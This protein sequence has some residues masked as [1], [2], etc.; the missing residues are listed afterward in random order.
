[1]K[2]FWVVTPLSTSLSQICLG[3]SVLFSF[4]FYTASTKFPKLSHLHLTIFGIY[5][6]FLLFP[7]ALDPNPDWL[8]VFI[9]SEFGDVWMISAF[10]LIPL[11]K[12]EKSE[13]L[14]YILF[15]GILLILSGFFSYL[16]PY[17]LSTFVMDGFQYLEG[18]RL[19]HL[20]Y[21]TEFGL[22]FYLPIGFQ[23]THLTYGGLLAIYLPVVFYQTI[24]ILKKNRRIGKRSNI[25]PLYI[26]ISLLGLFLLFLNQSRSILFGMS[27]T[28][29][30]FLSPSLQSFRRFWKQCALTLLTLF[31]LILILYHTNWLFQ[32]SIDDLF[33]K[34]SLENQRTWIHK[35]NWQILEKNWLLGIGSGNYRKEFEE[36]AKA[37][38]EE[39]P[40]TYYD[41]F[42]TPKSHAHFD[43][44]EFWILGGLPGGFLFL[45]FSFFVLESLNSLYS[46]RLLFLGVPILF[47]AGTTQCFLLDDEILL[48]FLTITALYLNGKSKKNNGIKKPSSISILLVL[49]LMIATGIAHQLSKT[50]TDDLFLHRVRHMNNTPSK[51]GQYTVNSNL[52]ILLPK[53]VL[54]PTYEFKITGC[55]DEVINFGSK[56][57]PRTKPIQLEVD[58]RPYV[59]DTDKPKIWIQVRKRES[60]DQD[61]K[62]KLQRE[63][64]VERIPV[65]FADAK[66]TVSRIPKKLP[67]FTTEPEFVDFG[68][69]YE[70]GFGVERKLAPIRI[71]K[72]CE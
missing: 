72:N 28:Y 38:V 16:F 62:F 54:G 58:L 68:F 43:F 2:L 39:H 10:F 69:F 29:L 25:Y 18:R 37:I 7:L 1:M 48:P 21:Q 35:I 44:L 13:L 19:P 6:S 5:L 23:N 9:K 33:A 71:G 45:L 42:I 52:S 27:A 53:T 20:L 64:E 70:F 55:L 59:N 49:Y 46:K 50:P 32:R 51:W 3:F 17:R 41:L 57:I 4:A 26:G 14:K 60:F 47:Y 22:G 30:I 24:R 36:S 40:Y 15:G 8:Q 34:R 56:G 12:N 11:R 66:F 67:K 63:W 31:T 61:Q 65:S